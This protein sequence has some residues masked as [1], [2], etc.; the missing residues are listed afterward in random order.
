M[1]LKTLEKI[2]L[3]IYELDPEKFVSVKKEKA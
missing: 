1:F 3:E 2:S